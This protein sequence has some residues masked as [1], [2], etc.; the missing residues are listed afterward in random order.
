V[1]EGKNEE[2]QEVGGERVGESGDGG[3]GGRGGCVGENA[4]EGRRGEGLDEWA[5][6]VWR[7]REGGR[8]FVGGVGCGGE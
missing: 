3:E 7:S 8:G 2:G 4:D 6:V 5:R 1:V